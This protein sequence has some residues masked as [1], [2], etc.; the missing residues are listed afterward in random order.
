MA[1]ARPRKRGSKSGLTP[2]KSGARTGYE[3]KYWRMAD[4][5]RDSLDAV[6]PYKRLKTFRKNC[7]LGGNQ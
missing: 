4:A 7:V 2:K 5:L 3:A 6:D 1:R